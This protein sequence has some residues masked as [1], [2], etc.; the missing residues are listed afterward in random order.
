[1]KKIFY[2]VKYKSLGSK[3][4]RVK[5]FD[6]LADAKAFSQ[7]GVREKPVAH[8]FTREYSI[9]EM[10]YLIESQ[11]VKLPIRNYT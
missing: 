2:S 3:G 5:W 1:M 10:G 11:K 7:D 4:A 9:E 8:T 6:N